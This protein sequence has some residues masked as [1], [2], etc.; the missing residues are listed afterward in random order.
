MIMVKTRLDRP[1]GLAS[2]LSGPVTALSWV[3]AKRI[4]GPQ[5][6][7]TGS[8]PSGVPTEGVLPRRSTPRLFVTDTDTPDSLKSSELLVG[9]LAVSFSICWS[10]K[11]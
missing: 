11:N 10:C 8:P 2:L 5:Q 6:S 1:S 4:A 9:L 3:C 7:P